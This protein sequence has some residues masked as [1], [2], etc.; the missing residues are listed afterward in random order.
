MCF[1]LCIWKHCAEKGA[2]AFP[3]QWTLDGDLLLHLVHDSAPH[4]PGPLGAHFGG[5]GFCSVVEQ[6]WHVWS[7]GLQ[8][9]AEKKPSSFRTS[10]VFTLDTSVCIGSLY[11]LFKLGEVSGNG[12]CRL[13]LWGGWC[14]PAPVWFCRYHT[15]GQVLSQK[16]G[17]HSTDKNPCF[18]CCLVI[19]AYCKNKSDECRVGGKG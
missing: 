11:A 3:R 14:V 4:H 2:P 15:V 17:R 8:S 10:R 1:T 5:Q 13:H 6:V 9:L 18:A 19:Q 7:P 12:S 16:K